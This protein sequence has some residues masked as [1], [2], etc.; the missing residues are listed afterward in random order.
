MAMQEMGR[1]GQCRVED[2]PIGLVATF[3]FEKP[4]STPKRVVHKI[5]K[6]DYDKLARSLSDAL[7]GIVYKD[8]SQ[9][10]FGQQEKKFGSPSRVEVRC[11]T[12]ENAEQGAG[13]FPGGA[14]QLDAL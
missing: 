1:S 8:D 12:I 7:S 10:V 14:A 13:L 5:T 4:K 2:L 6:P 11:W 9:I 3:Y